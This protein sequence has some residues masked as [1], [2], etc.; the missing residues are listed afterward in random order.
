MNAA[1]AIYVAVAH[2][3]TV[4]SRV[5]HH[6]ILRADSDILLRADFIGVSAVPTTHVTVLQAVNSVA[7]TVPQ[8][9]L[10]TLLR[11]VVKRF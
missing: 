5:V 11:P 10:K 8:R 1:A 9:D 4:I 3:N 2:V 7:A 6:A